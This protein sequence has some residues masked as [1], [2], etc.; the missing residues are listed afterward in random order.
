MFL[1]WKEFHHKNSD[2]ESIA[3]SWNGGPK[4]PKSSRTLPYWEKVEKQLNIK[5]N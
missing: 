3:R 5:N 2:F 1:I 4:G